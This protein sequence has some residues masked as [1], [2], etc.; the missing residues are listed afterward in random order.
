GP[1]GAPAVV[2]IGAK[3]IT[4]PSAAGLPKD[5][6]K[7]VKIAGEGRIKA[8]LAGAGYPAKAD[9]A[10]I[11]YPGAFAVLVLFV[12]A[13]AALYGPMA[14]CLVELFPTRIRYTAMSL[15]YNIGTGWVGGFVPFTAFAIVT[16]VGNIYSGLW[17]PFGFTLIA[18]VACLL[19]LPETKDRPLDG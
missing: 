10:R 5:V 19:F 16:A 17:Y 3:A 4:T 6:A 15:P 11:N 13:A 7:A 1:A 8:G 2:R 12:V 18:V 14:A 9:P